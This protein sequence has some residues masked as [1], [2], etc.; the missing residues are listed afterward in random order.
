MTEP[1]ANAVP[2]PQA[3][4]AH[5]VALCCLCLGLL[6]L[7]QWQQGQLLGAVLVVLVGA[8]SLL[9]RIRVGPLLIV[10]L[11]GGLQMVHQSQFGAPFLREGAFASQMH[12]W[13]ISAGVLGYV[14]GHYRLQTFWHSLWPEDMRQ[15]AGPPTRPFPWLRRRQPLVQEKRPQQHLTPHEL[16]WLLMSLP[17]WALIGC[18]T[19]A[20][21]G[22]RWNVAGFELS[23]VRLLLTILFLGIVFFV[24]RF[25]LGYW[26]HRRRDDEAARLFLQEMLWKETRGEQR[27]LNRWLAWSKKSKLPS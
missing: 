2:L 17:A 19:W 26:R 6:F 22:Q 3:S 24:G 21:L 15:K 14:L 25:V 27:R 13:L 18:L 11:V 8:L 20:V 12:D 7:A 4:P 23:I 9:S 10:V 5:Y 16:V 1:S